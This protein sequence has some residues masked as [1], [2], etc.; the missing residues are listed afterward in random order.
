[1]RDVKL[2]M[3]GFEAFQKKINLDLLWV[4][5]YDSEFDRKK[6]YKKAAQ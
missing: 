5:T 4:I 6:G 3:T 2:E 1:M